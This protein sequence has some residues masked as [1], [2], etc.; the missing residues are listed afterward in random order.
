MEDLVTPQQN[1]T[2][3]QYLELEKEA[4]IRHEYVGGQLRAMTGATRR[5]NL[6][7]QNIVFALRQVARGTTC[8]TY[9]SEVKVQT[10]DRVI[11]YPD[12]MVTCNPESDDPCVISEPCLLIEVVSHT[13]EVKDRREKLVAYKTIPTL[14]AYLI[15]DQARRRVD[16]HFR[17]DQGEWRRTTVIGDAAIP[18]P[19][20]NGALA[21]PDIY[22]GVLD[23]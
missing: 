16:R 8:R 23:D 2:L 11:Y 10:P 12:V 1:M 15:V 18:L 4:P 19:C 14:E 21:M 6:I 13:T 7:A 3:E 5:H 17:D 22:E 9:M 20:S